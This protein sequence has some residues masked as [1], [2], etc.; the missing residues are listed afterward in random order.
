MVA[1]SCFSIVSYCPERAISG[2]GYTGDALAIDALAT[3]VRTT[4]SLALRL[5]EKIGECL[6]ASSSGKV[7]RTIDVSERGL[8]GALIF[9][10]SGL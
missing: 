1:Y 6:N 8:A 3:L 4:P 5:T 7:R 9:R 10:V 2:T